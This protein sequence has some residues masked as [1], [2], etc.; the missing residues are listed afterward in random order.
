MNPMGKRPAFLSQCSLNGYR[1]KFIL[2]IFADFPCYRCFFFLIAIRQDDFL[3]KYLG[4]LSSRFYRIRKF[5]LNIKESL[6][7]QFIQ[8]PVCI[9]SQHDLVLRLEFYRQ[10][11]ISGFTQIS[12]IPTVSHINK[13]SVFRIH[14]YYTGTLCIV[15]RIFALVGTGISHAGPRSQRIVGYRIL[16]RIRAPASTP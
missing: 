10:P 7:L 12:C 13:F 14:R 8:C 1:P 6:S 16:R 11:D 15:S 2:F 9:S 5:C 3:R 4:D